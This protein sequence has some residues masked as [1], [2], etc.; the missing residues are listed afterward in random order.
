M[1]SA[2]L[3]SNISEIDDDDQNT[4]KD[5]VMSVT[6]KSTHKSSDHP[7]E[8]HGLICMQLVYATGM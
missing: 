4:T 6:C 5:G 1:N 3:L 8:L 2:Q 7:G